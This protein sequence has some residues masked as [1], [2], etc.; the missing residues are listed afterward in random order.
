MKAFLQNGHTGIG[1]L[2]NFVAVVTIPKQILVIV[3]CNNINREFSPTMARS[4]L[5]ELYSPKPSGFHIKAKNTNI[6]DGIR[7]FNISVLE[8]SSVECLLTSSKLMKA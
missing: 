7:L 1:D 3:S 8:I 4:S 6:N 5:H 2:G